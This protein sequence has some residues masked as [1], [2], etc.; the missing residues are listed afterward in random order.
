MTDRLV[1]ALARGPLVLDAAMGTRL[2]T[3]GLN[4]GA[5]DPCLWNHDRPGEVAAIHARDVAAGAEALLTNTFG[6]NRAWLARF[7]LPGRVVAINRRA[8]ALA[9]DA[10]GPDRLILGSIG[11]TAADDPVACREQAEALIEAG[12]D[13][14]IFE[15]HR[16]A[17]A[18][19][20]LSAVRPI[21]TVPLLVSLVAWPD[22]VSG[23][24]RRLA[25]LGASALGGNCQPGMGPALRL[26]ETLRRAIDLPIIVKPAASGPGLPLPA[27]PSSFAAAVPRLL[28]LGPVL[29]GGCCGATEAHVAALRDACYAGMGRSMQPEPEAG[30]TP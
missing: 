17:Q 15:T 14:L 27:D 1:A 24:A 5:D 20:A 29:V 23:A 28:A 18:E 3:R 21:A 9:R 13:A 4:L 10:A 8:V 25:D 26:A 11:P 12:A 6:A 19:V 2:V 22:D 7:G 30:R 16:D